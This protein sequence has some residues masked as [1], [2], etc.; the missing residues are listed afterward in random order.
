MTERAGRELFLQVGFDAASLLL[1]REVAIDRN[2]S[3]CEA[4]LIVG[5]L[6][7]ARALGIAPQHTLVDEA[8]FAVESVLQAGDVGPVVIVAAQRGI[9]AK[10]P[11][12]EHRLQLRANIA[13]PQ[14]QVR[15][16]GIAQ[17]VTEGDFQQAGTA[18]EVARIDILLDRRGVGLLARA[19][20]N[21]GQNRKIIASEALDGCRLDTRVIAA[22]GTHELAALA[23][24]PGPQRRVDRTHG[25][26]STNRRAAVKRRCRTVQHLDLVHETGAD[27]VARRVGEAADIELVAY[28]NPVDQNGH[29]VAADAAY[30]DA[31]GAE[32]GTRRFVVDP[33]GVAEYVG[34]RIR[35]FHVHVITCEDADGCRDVPAGTGMLVRHHDDL[36]HV[37]LPDLLMRVEP[38]VPGN[39]GVEWQAE[40]QYGQCGTRTEHSQNSA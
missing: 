8:G 29:P 7:D 6:L 9:T 17:W 21:A 39:S 34:H 4:A 13:V 25:D 27:E 20:G 12:T 40:C 18:P 11:G 31:L 15:L 32:S 28:R 1:E 23:P 22:P 35:Q 33:R 36:F 5:L 37:R 10:S 30:V 2:G 38:G 26:D 3:R 16:Q 24:L 19:P 14:V